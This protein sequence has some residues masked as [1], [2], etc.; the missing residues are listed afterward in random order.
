M[1]KSH[2][3]VLPTYHLIIEHHTGVLDMESYKKFKALLL[4]DASYSPNYNY[5]IN[6]KNVEFKIKPEEIKEYASSLK[7][8]PKVFGNKNLAI[9]TK[10]PD[11]T[12]PVTIYKMKQQGINQSVEV[13]ST[14]EVALQWLNSSLT[15]KEL[16]SL[17]LK[18][19]N[20]PSLI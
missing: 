12:V 16:D 9:I 10:T 6:F 7:Q 4:N 15:A 14:Y 19:K 3:K 1:L 20:Q 8:N 13:F 11:Q 5:I 2:Y 18:L 17:F